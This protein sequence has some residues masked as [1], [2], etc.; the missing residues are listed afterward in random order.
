M[1][2]VNACV[3]N[4]APHRVAHTARKMADAPC[5]IKMI[6]FKTMLLFPVFSCDV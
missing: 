3:I 6:V 1:D 5:R 2:S 4:D